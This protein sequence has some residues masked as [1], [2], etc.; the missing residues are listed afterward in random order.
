MGLFRVLFGRTKDDSPDV[1]GRYPEYMQV[2]ALPERRYLKT[3]RLL[4]LFIFLNMAAMI[5]IAGFFTYIADRIDISI[6]NRK[7][8]N[9]YSIDSSRQVL[10]PAEYSTKNVKA[11]ELFAES[12]LRSYIYNRHSVVWENKIMTQRWDVGG[13]VAGY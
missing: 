10:I 7:A 3:S 2:K 6:A 4:A 12:L 5:A 9:L 8:V 13:P 1:L 11:L